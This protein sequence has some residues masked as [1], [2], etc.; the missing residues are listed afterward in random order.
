MNVVIPMAGLGSRFSEAGYDLPKPFIDVNGQPM[1]ARVLEN[2][3]YPGARY[4]LLSRREH[5]E[6][7]NDI[8]SELKK[9]FSV[10]FRSISSVTEGTAAT[11]LFARDIFANEEPLLI[12][13]CD[14][15]VD[16]GIVDMIDSCRDQNLDGSI[17]VFEDEKRD[18][19]WSFVKLDDHGLVTEAKEKQPISSL[20]TVGIYLFSRGVDFREA[21]IE[22]IIRNERTNNEFYTCPTYNYLIE[23]GR[24]IAIYKIEQAAMH[25]IGTPEDLDDYR[26]ISIA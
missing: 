5:L 24:R 3:Y 12:A 25:G 21:A 6:N 4:T 26:A 9:E 20:A 17:M 1:I 15:I 18:P 13:N 11:L 14:Q 23:H 8:V 2:L 22:M 7:H 10:E 16:G 19:K